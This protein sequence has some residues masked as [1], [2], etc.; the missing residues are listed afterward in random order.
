MCLGSPGDVGKGWD[1]CWYSREEPPRSAV[2]QLSLSPAL[3][4]CPQRTPLSH[5]AVAATSSELSGSAEVERTTVLPQ[6]KQSKQ[7]M[8]PFLWPF[9]SFCL[10]VTQPLVSLLHLHC[11]KCSG[12]Q[13]LA[14]WV[15]SVLRAWV[16][17]AAARGVL[18]LH[19]EHL[20]A[21]RLA[22]ALGSWPGWS[23][24]TV[25]GC[26]SL[27]RSAGGFVAIHSSWGR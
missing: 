14:A 10:S 19:Q 20:Q 15:C 1:G 17:L 22:E 21:I 6:L 9:F 11:F 27:S 26:P 13:E 5:S 8:R 3:R 16:W 24:G 7:Q 23:E 18:D 2:S 25:Q 4:V 12:S